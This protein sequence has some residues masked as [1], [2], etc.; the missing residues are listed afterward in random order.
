M[1]VSLVAIAFWVPAQL[2]AQNTALLDSID[3][4]ADSSWEMA[5]RIW[6]WAETGYK[7]KQSAALLADALE[8]AGFKVVRGVAGIPTAFTATIGSGKPVIGIM[9]EYDALPGLSQDAVPYRKPRPGD[10]NGH[11]CGHHLFG[12]ASLSACLA[13]GE[14][15]QAGKLNGTLRFFGCPAEEGGSARVFMVREGLFKD[16]DI[17]LHWH[18]ASINSAGSKSNIRRT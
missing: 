4:R 11:G 18:P 6:E 14:Q 13:L 3:R 15:I 7:E 16:C 1:K 17:A 8:K 10:G 9:G 2:F 12:V 5:R